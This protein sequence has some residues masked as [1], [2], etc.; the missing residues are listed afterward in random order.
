MADL[1]D[2]VVEIG[3]LTEN[4]ITGNGAFD[5]LMSSVSKHIAQE[6]SASRIKGADYA[7]VYL[8]SIQSVLDRAL[9]FVLTQPE[10]NL[11][12]QILEIERQK[13]LIDKDISEEQKALLAAQTLKTLAEVNLVNA[14]ITVTNAEAPRVEAQTALLAQQ[15]TNAVIEA[16]I[17][18]NNAA[19]VLKET[20]LVAEQITEV[21]ARAD[22]IGQQAINAVAE[23]ALIES[24]ALKT[25]AE[26]AL[27]GNQADKVQSE[28]ELIDEQ[29]LNV[30]VEK[31]FT[32]QRTAN[33]VI[34]G[35]VLEATEC[36]LKAEFDVLV[37]TK[38]KIAA[39][40]ALLTQ[41]R[42][43][44]VAQ[45]NSAGV[46]SNSVIGKQ[47]QLY[48]AQIAGFQRDAEQKAAQIMANSWGVRRT[49]SENEPA[50]SSNKLWDPEI[51]KAIGKML[52][53]VG[54]V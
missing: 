24:N 49:T 41:K 34:E 13:A 42:V 37:E 17:L 43:T 35:T 36:K 50:N 32:V 6:Y 14:Q 19:K 28:L 23:K 39:E 7:N 46:D 1:N 31:A 30:I 3:D 45:V 53:G 12:L 25:T 21:S 48:G 5:I 9:E 10:L 20:D 16:G 29:K 22:L 8:G 47:T 38:A 26:I 54:A 44:E 4:S 11:K 27:V 18:T 2:Q 51:G 52:Q 33:A 15:R 40:T